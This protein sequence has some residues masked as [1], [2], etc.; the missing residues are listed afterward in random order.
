MIQPLNSNQMVA[1]RY[2]P[3]PYTKNH[4]IITYTLG[5]PSSLVARK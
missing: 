3:M 1:G 2:H 5:G 4:M